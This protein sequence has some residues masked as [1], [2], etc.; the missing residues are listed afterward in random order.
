MRHPVP[1]KYLTTAGLIPRRFIATTRAPCHDHAPVAF[2]TYPFSSSPFA[3]PHDSTEDDLH[4][5]PPYPLLTT[6]TWPCPCSLRS[7]V[8]VQPHPSESITRIQWLLPGEETLPKKER[9]EK[10]RVL[11]WKG[12]RQ[13]FLDGVKTGRYAARGGE[14]GRWILGVIEVIFG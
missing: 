10:S 3:Y 14:T 12:E 4:C 7:Q 1:E 8:C 9:N 6:R 5:L 13:A 11:L 2:E